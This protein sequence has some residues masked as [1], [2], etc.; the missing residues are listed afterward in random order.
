MGFELITPFESKVEVCTLQKCML[1]TTNYGNLNFRNIISFDLKIDVCNTKVLT[2]T[3]YDIL[4]FRYIIP[5]Q[6]FVLFMFFWLMN[7]II[8]VGQMTLA[9]AF[10]SYYWAVN[11]PNDIPTM[12]VLSSFYRA[13]R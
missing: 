3:I 6:L 9:G 1:S 8:A 2:T 11:K 13:F 7:F 10:A 5:L 4:Y 12:P